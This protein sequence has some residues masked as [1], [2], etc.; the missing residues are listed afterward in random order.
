MEQV[1]D[2]DAP[3]FDSASVEC[4]VQPCPQRLSADVPLM[5]PLAPPTEL[6]VVTVTQRTQQDMSFWSSSV[7]EERERLL[8][9]FIQGATQI[10]H[11]LWAEGHWA[12]FIEPS[13]GLPFFGPYT[14]L[15]LFETDDRVSSLGF[16]VDD[17]GCCRVLRHALWGTHVFMGTIFTS[18]NAK[19]SGV[20]EALQGGA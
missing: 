13:S 1:D 19:D 3:V 17:L 8:Q 11:E 6:T 7:E 12:D 15:P 9:T 20:M 2:R 10:C 5:F 16:T 18:A 14:N 4:V